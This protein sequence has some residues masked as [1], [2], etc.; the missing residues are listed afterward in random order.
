MSRLAAIAHQ[1]PS[2][3]LQSQSDDGRFRCATI[4]RYFSDRR[5]LPPINPKR[6][7]I[8]AIQE[9]VG[10][11]SDQHEFDI[12]LCTTVWALQDE[13]DRQ[14]LGP[15]MERSYPDRTMETIM[16]HS[17]IFLH[18]ISEIETSEKCRRSPR[19][20]ISEAKV[21]QPPV[22]FSPPITQY[23]PPRPF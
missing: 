3:G 15:Q 1:V 9:I 23:K 12:P 14:E 5:I 17:M 2:R 6:G 13:M 11:E 19:L 16:I 10:N 7:K 20:G 8:G 22:Q 18:V 4:R 21:V